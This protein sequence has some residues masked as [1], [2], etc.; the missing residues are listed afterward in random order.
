[1][2]VTLTQTRTSIP[3]APPLPPRYSDDDE[4]PKPRPNSP[5]RTRKEVAEYLRLKNVEAVDNL[6]IRVETIN[7]GG[8]RPGKLRCRKIGGRILVS[9]KDVERY[10]PE[11]ED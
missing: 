9:W 1:M 11:I 3:P 8:Y 4:A 10:A 5:W 6:L 2:I 7:G